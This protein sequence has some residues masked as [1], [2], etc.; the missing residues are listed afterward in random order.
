M[1][2]IVM[3]LTVLAAPMFALSEVSDVEMSYHSDYDYYSMKISGHFEANFQ[4]FLDTDNNKR[5]GYTRKKENPKAIGADYLIEGSNLFKYEGK[6][7]SGNWDGWRY[8][9][10]LNSFGDP[11][12]WISSSEIV[13]DL[14][15]EFFNIGNRFNYGV[16][17][18]NSNWGV[19]DSYPKK[20]NRLMLRYSKPSQ[21]YASGDRGFVYK[22]LDEITFSESSER[23]DI[24]VTRN[25]DNALLINTNG[26][27]VF[28]NSPCSSRVKVS[29]KIAL[30]SGGFDV[31]YS[32]RNLSNSKKALPVLKIPGINFGDTDVLKILNPLFKHY[33]EERDITTEQNY[34]KEGG[35]KAHA[36]GSNYFAVANAVRTVKINGTNTKYELHF[37]YGKDD[38]DGN[39]QFVYSPVI[40]A[41]NNDV[42]VGSSLNLNSKYKRERLHVKM[43]IEKEQNGRWSYRYDLSGNEIAAKGR[44]NLTVSVRFA[45]K[46]KWIFTLYP[47][48]ELLNCSLE[49]EKNIPT[50]KDLRPIQ[51][52]N[53]AVHDANHLSDKSRAW[54]MDL[55]GQW[56]KEY[57]A[58]LPLRKSLEKVGEEL[59]ANGYSRSAIWNFTGLYKNNEKTVYGEMPEQL[60]FQF[61]SSTKGKYQI[62]PK[63][64]ED[65]MTDILNNG[66]SEYNGIEMGYDWG[67]AGNIP[68]GKN[69][70]PLPTCVWQPYNIVPF[71]YFDKSHRKYAQYYLNEAKKLQGIFVPKFIRLD[72]FIRMDLDG[73][74]KW[75]KH[76]QKSLPNTTF[77][78]ESSIDYMHARSASILQLDSTQVWVNGS[79]KIGSK[80]EHTLTQPDLLAHYL[81]PG[82]ESIVAIEQSLFRH[83]EDPEQRS[84]YL[85][86]LIALG[87]TPLISFWGFNYIINVENID[88]SVN[89]CFD[90]KD[91]DGDGK[92]DWPYDENC[93]IGDMN[94]DAMHQLKEK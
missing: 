34:L 24:S 19:D 26:T 55:T 72:A 61:V 5:T 38:K 52:I 43:S 62:L 40:V 82:A 73:R 32:I 87:Y 48:K 93:R 23:K 20:G 25:R 12:V 74:V 76:L 60:P 6:N 1:K 79:G 77:A 83:R 71:N 53:F 69:N 37:P 70:K 58:K 7:G 11:Y 47:Y 39:E 50:K 41:T 89:Q 29:H 63:Y 85:E 88:T 84:R 42:A 31:K 16:R 18:L 59:S 94:A 64:M 17:A 80:E 14:S 2:K 45:D 49:G 46:D 54:S 44:L 66:L 90:G 15:R 36:D 57:T 27:G 13:I 78:L 28:H 91:N 9:Y 30:K 8:L 33:L 92:V 4:V 3:A 21:G 56:S 75:L 65:N 51:A 22:N 67:I 86:D 68:I 35:G 10:D 81:N